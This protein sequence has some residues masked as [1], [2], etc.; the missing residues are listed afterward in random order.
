LDRD[1][2]KTGSNN[3]TQWNFCSV[4]PYAAGCIADEKN[5][6]NSSTLLNQ[7]NFEDQIF[8]LIFPLCE[9]MSKAITLANSPSASHLPGYKQGIV[10]A[11]N[12]G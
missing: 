12:C 5:L 7:K 10:K 6:I 9:V 4:C 11:P 2:V 8:S 3:S 1:G